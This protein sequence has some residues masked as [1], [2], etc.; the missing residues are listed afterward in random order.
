M[1]E[2][3]SISPKHDQIMSWLIAN[4]GAPMSLCAREYGV[5]Q[6]WLSCIV[7]SDLFQSKL[8]ERQD[9]AFSEVAISVKDRITALAHESL[10]R[11]SEKIIVE[12]DVEKITNVAE[13]TIKALGFAP[14]QGQRG[15]SNQTLIFAASKEMLSE[16]RNLM[17]AVSG[18][19]NAQRL[20]S[21]TAPLEIDITPEQETF[22]ET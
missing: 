17:D 11:L 4:A 13:M 7:H 12:Q 14:T 8:K 6:S 5:T 2:L 15:P 3:K 21:P 10:E 9:L 1:S 19:S 18:L 16:A 20:P 22:D